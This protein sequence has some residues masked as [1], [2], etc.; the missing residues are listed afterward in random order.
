MGAAYPLDAMG[1]PG[2]RMPQQRQR[3]L[4]AMD[5]QREM[6]KGSTDS[7]LLAMLAQE[8]MYGYQLVKELEGRSNGY[9]QFREGTLYPALHRL[10]KDGLLG[11]RW[12]PS[13]SGQKRRY[14]FVTDAGRHALATRQSQW[15]GFAKAVSMVLAPARS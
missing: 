2:Y 8:P 11:A 1:K 5:Y 4:D 12:E 3:L 13:P 15:Q 10:E 6:L 9:F 14:Y 7:L